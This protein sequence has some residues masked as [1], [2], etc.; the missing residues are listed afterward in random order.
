MTLKSLGKTLLPPAAIPLVKRI[1]GRSDEQLRQKYL[2]QG[3]IPWSVGYGIYK[4]DLI[5]TTLRNADLMNRFQQGQALPEGYGIGI[6]ERCV[7]YPWLFAHLPAT[8]NPVLDAGSVLNHE[9]LLNHSA[10]SQKTVHIVTLAPE[11]VCFW[12][13]GIS[14]LFT[15]LR[16]LPLRSNY[17][18]VIVCLSTLEHVGCDNSLYTKSDAGLENNP[19]T[20]TQAIAELHRVLKPNGQLLLSVPFGTYQHFGSFQQFDSELLKQAIAAFNPAE[21]VNSTFYRYAESGWNIATEDAC[22]HSRYADAVGW[23]KADQ[24]SAQAAVHQAPDFAAAA[25]AVACI[26]LIKSSS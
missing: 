23:V 22:R 9:F 18:D 5:E 7:E 20:F 13:R 16:H 24:S 1:V 6:D 8:A 15:D 4:R 17:Y 10:L 3:R 26:Q 11:E 21:S 12:E 19:E 14:Y 25:R 2:R